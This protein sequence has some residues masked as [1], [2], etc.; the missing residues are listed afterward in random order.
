MPYDYGKFKEAFRAS[1]EALQPFRENRLNALRQYVGDKYSWNG[2]KEPVPVNMIKMLVET[3]T[4]NLL[5]GVPQVMITT[6]HKQLRPYAESMQL[7]VNQALKDAKPTRHFQEAIADSMFVMGIM[8][9][10]I[11]DEIDQST[12]SISFEGGIFLSPV[13]LDDFVMDMSV[14]SVYAASWYGCRYT[15]PKEVIEKAYKK[16]VEAR[17]LGWSNESGDERDN[18]SRYPSSS[19]NIDEHEVKAEVWEIYFPSE[20][21]IRIYEHGD[22]G[23]GQELDEYD[24]EGPS[25]GPYS[26][27]YYSKP[28]NSAMPTAPVMDL[29][30]LHMSANKLWRKADRQAQRQK[31]VGVVGTT[32]ED[33]GR[34]VVQASDGQM[35][36][37]DDPKAVGNVNFGGVNP[38][39]INFFNMVWQQF[40]MFGNN[41]SV[42]AGLG[43]QSPTATQDTLLHNAANK[44]VARM[45]ESV[46]QFT[47]DII[48]KIVWYMWNDPVLEMQIRKKVE[49]TNIVVDSIWGPNERVGDFMAYNIDVNPHSLRSMS[50]GE[51]LMGLQS[52]LANVMMP[53]MPYIQAQGGVPNAEVISKTWADLSGD[54]AIND[55]I[56]WTGAPQAA[57]EPPMT[58]PNKPPGQ[59]R[60]YERISRAADNPMGNL[61][62]I[63]RNM[64]RAAQTSPEGMTQ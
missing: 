48:E 29:I 46:V 37:L 39:N 2:A 57:P 50:P 43:A 63:G 21:R 13:S 11:A 8:K 53:M 6:R 38:D 60:R 9:V 7:A 1:R 42:L 23:I 5:S 12:D 54:P 4:T 49:N 3:N 26:F 52:Y 32:G 61:Q 58:P 24:Y 44:I 15:A 14:R 19:R 16:K 33:D 47:R 22:D 64:G 55:F 30:D 17:D 59:T 41:L 36:R 25:S 10:G 40:N 18:L 20:K 28:T 31:Y 45:Q 35:I 51:R 34:R 27:L 56:Q 62:Q